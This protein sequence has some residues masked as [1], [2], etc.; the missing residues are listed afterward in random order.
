MTIDWSPYREILSGHI[1]RTATQLSTIS[2]RTAGRNTSACAAATV[3][4]SQIAFVSE[5]ES[6][7]SKPWM[8][9]YRDPRRH[10]GRQ[11][12]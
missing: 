1:V 8:H 12:V 9:G 3:V 4:V 10:P 5:L 7:G 11:D 6:F 2:T